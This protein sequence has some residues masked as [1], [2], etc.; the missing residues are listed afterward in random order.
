MHANLE[1][2]AHLVG[3]ITQASSGRTWRPRAIS[4]MKLRAFIPPGEILELEA[5][6]EESSDHAAE[7]LVETRR[8]KRLL[9]SARVRFVSEGSP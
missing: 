4:D 6:M 1:L 5:Q 2:A 7:L 8:G 9:G 3:E